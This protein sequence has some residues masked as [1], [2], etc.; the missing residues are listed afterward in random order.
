[1]TTNFTPP[2]RSDLA[3]ERPYGAPQLSVPVALNVNENTH[4]L[5]SDL[6]TALIAAFEEIVSKLN[7]YP[8][9][10]FL[11]LRSAI[12]RH[13]GHQ[14]EADQ[15]W[16]ANGSNEILQQLFLAFGGAG[17]SA[18]SFVP[19]YSMYENLA[20]IS[21]TSFIRVSRGSDFAIDQGSI[22][23]AVGHH[24]PDLVLI[25]NPN[26]PTGTLTPLAVISAVAAATSGLVVVDEAYAE[27]SD[28][29]SALSLLQHH[30]N[31]V[32]SRTM[33][34]A[35]SFAGVRLGYLATHPAIIDALRV[36]RLPYHLSSLTQAAA[37]TALQF[38]ERMLA[39]VHDIVAQRV[40]MSLALE[41]LG[42]KPFPS[43]S[44]F[45]LVGGFRSPEDTFAELLS[46]G[47]LVRNVGIANTLRFTIGT[48]SENDQLLA[49]LAKSALD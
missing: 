34:K 18:M 41:G 20:L 17:R 36:V 29:D 35:F 12:A 32:V 8:D 38:A 10:E 46:A 14:L 25:C 23:E 31:L 16:A 7:R 9:R 13:L 4:D 49:A 24:K 1:M 26:N 27:F 11:D 40:R 47:I 3:S 33:S 5:P 44:N 6:K 48:E 19:S 42:L 37:I 45:L 15:V 21:A 39:S 2:I 43:A 28:Q 22:L 30:P